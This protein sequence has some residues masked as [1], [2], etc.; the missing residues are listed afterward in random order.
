MLTI[1]VFNF[2][3][4]TLRRFPTPVEFW[5]ALI[6]ALIVGFHLYQKQKKRKK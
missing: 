2:Y 6:I 3:L 1:L 5:L 4:G